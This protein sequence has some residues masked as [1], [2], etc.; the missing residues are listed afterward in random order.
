[1]YRQLMGLQQL[2]VRTFSSTARRQVENKIKD[3]QKFY[4]EDNG[5]PIHLKGGTMDALMYKT[6]MVGC[7]CGTIYLLY[8]LY[9][10]AMPKKG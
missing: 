5:V 8:S 1:M 6:T 4:Q 2:S 3:K 9:Q 10:A 7:V